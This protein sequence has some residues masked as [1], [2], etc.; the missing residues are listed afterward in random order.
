MCVYIYIYIYIYIHI[1]IYIYV[2]FIERPKKEKMVRG[3]EFSNLVFP[4]GSL[5]KNSEDTVAG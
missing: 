3:K 1:Y 4:A 5:M 2:Y